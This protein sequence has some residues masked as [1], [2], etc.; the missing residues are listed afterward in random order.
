MTTKLKWLPR[1]LLL[2]PNLALCTT[3]AQYHQAL[4]HLKCTTDREWLSQR[5]AGKYL[6]LTNET[7]LMTV[8]VYIRPTD[9]KLHDLATLVH[10]AVHVWQCFKEHIGETNPGRETEAYAIESIWRTLMADYARQTDTD[11]KTA[12]PAVPRKTD[13]AGTPSSGAIHDDRQSTLA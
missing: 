4:K 3:E 6:A 9:N 1:T 2:G 12:M 7:G 5:A 13:A 10:E 11:P 8:L